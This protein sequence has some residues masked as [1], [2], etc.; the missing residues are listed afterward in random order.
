MPTPFLKRPVLL[1]LSV[2]AIVLLGSALISSNQVSFNEFTKAVLS[3][4]KY[5]PSTMTSSWTSPLSGFLDRADSYR[6]SPTDFQPPRSAL[7]LAVLR[8]APVDPEGFTLAVFSA[9][10]KDDDSKQHYAVDKF[11]RVKV[12]QEGD[13][14]TLKKLLKNVQELPRTE[15]Y[16]N[17]WVLKQDRTSQ[18]IDRI[19]IPKSTLSDEP[20]SRYDEEYEETSVQGFDYQK[21]EL[22]RPVEGL[23][24]LPKSLWEVTGAVL[25]ARRFAKWIIACPSLEA[26]NWPVA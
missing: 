2:V 6:R 20:K 13:V 11:G 9:D 24:E 5:I 1:L 26:Q 15:N 7:E 25:E 23:E 17:T 3:K 16:R 18:P 8:N 14:G 21:K 19:L 12:L 22:K 4:S 10:S